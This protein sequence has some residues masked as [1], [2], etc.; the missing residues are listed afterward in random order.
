VEGSGADEVV[1]LPRTLRAYAFHCSEDQALHPLRI[2]LE[3]SQPLG[4]TRAVCRSPLRPLE[5]FRGSSIEQG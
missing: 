4:R 2:N 5:S 1:R 3:N